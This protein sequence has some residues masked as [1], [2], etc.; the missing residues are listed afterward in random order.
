[1]YNHASADYQ[2]PIC[3]A[4][5]GVETEATWIRPQD[6]FF[7][8]DLVLSFISSKFIAGNEGH[9]IIVPVEHFENLYDMPDEVSHRIMD[10]AKRVAIA[11]KNVR[12]CD[13]VTLLQKNEP[14]GAQHAF[15]F[16]LHVVPRFNGDK[17]HQELLS[18]HRSEPH[19]R[20]AYATALRNIV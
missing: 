16:H 20:I 17:F 6:I 8:D 4:V 13:G 1:M 11:L 15:H 3:L 7:R 18:A 10:L 2:C 12:N 19:E 9:P 14:A 5:D